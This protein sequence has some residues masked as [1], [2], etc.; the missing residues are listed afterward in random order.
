MLEHFRQKGW[1]VVAGIAMVVCL[2]GCSTNEAT[3][4]S[5]FD[6][7]ST[8]QEIQLG[9]EAMP[10]LVKEYGGE[11][12]SPQLR[13]YV[14]EV[15]MKLAKQT[16]A[17]NPNLPWKFTVLDSDVINAFALPGGKVFISRALMLQMR[18]EAELAAVLGHEVGHVTAH[19]IDERVS[20]AQGISLG[21]QIL[22]EVLG[23]SGP[24]YADLANLIVG[25]GGQGYLL[26][27]GRD[28]E[29]ESDSLGLRYMTRAGYDPRGMIRVMEILAEASKGGGDAEILS[30]HPYPETRLKRI[31]KEL[32]DSYKSEMNNPNLKLYEDR[33]QQMAKPYL[34]LGSPTR[35][36]MGA[37]CA[38]CAAAH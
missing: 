14:T 16:E 23:Q 31:K 36:P 24:S 12:S 13:N 30:T 8:E 6:L 17:D 22:G 2:A 29:S 7:M 26:K 21:G 18:S 11:V 38:L 19:H 28:Q 33:W 32:D 5:Q 35:R 27:F 1:I 34:S 10:E 9:D 37:T 15:G 20:Q 3:G 25:V 4:R